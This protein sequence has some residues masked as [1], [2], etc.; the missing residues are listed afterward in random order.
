MVWLVEQQVVQLLDDSKLPRREPHAGEPVKCVQILETNSTRPHPVSAQSVPDADKRLPEIPELFGKGRHL[1]FRLDF[2]RPIG[3]TR[4]LQLPF[5][6][7]SIGVPVV[8][9]GR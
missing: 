1:Q 6:V 4:P 8:I 7:L 9:A 2:C 5:E 3:R